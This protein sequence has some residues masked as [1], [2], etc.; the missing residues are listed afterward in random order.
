MLRN[1]FSFGVVA[2]SCVFSLQQLVAGPLTS[3][4]VTKI[5]NRV[6]VIDPAKGD[7][8]AMIREVIKE[9]LGLQTGEK[10]RSE[11][12]FQYNTLTRIGAE[13]FFNFKTGKRDL[14]HAKSS[15]LCRSEGIGRREN[16]TPRRSWAITGTTILI[17]Y[18]PHRHIKMF[19]LE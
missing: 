12:L 14:P 1:T 8:S 4:K 13:T 15:M 9:D 7:H 11:L 18:I 17:E 5:I 3:A 10:S 6:S 19:V 16:S 2:A